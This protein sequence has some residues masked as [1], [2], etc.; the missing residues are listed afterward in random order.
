VL[1]AFVVAAFLT[2][3]VVSMIL[4]ALPL[5]I[6]YEISIFGAQVL[7]RRKAATAAAATAPKTD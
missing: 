7:A 2:P 1:L 6:L 5:M 3:D 4:M